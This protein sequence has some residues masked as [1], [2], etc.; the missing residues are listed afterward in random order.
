MTRTEKLSQHLARTEIFREL[1]PRLHRA[2]AEQCE[3]RSYKKEQ[4]IVCQGEAGHEFFL[5]LSGS[6]AVLLEDFA[7]WSEQRI[8]ELGT[9]QSFGES[10]LLTDTRRTATVK[11]EQDT[12]CA[13]LSRESFEKL[14]SKLPEVGLA[15][16]KYLAQR[17]A[18]QCQ[19]TGY[20]FVSGD[21]LVFNPKIYR[22]FP[23]ATLS[24]W[25]A[26]PLALNGRTITVALTRPNDAEAVKALQR[27]VPGFG[28]ELVACTFEDYRAF[29][30][31][32]LLD[33]QAPSAPSESHT[34]EI[35][36][37]DGTKVS[38]P[39]RSVVSAMHSSAESRV[40]AEMES[41]STLLLAHRKGELQ[42]FLPPLAKNETLN[43]RRQLDDLLND[44]SRPAE[45]H[46]VSL[47]LGGRPA[48]LA[49]T[50]LRSPARSRYSIERTD[51]DTAVPP[52]A[53]LFPSAAIANLVKGAL[54]WEG[55]TLLI[56]GPKNSGLSTTLYSLLQSRDEPLRRRN[57]VLFEEHPLVPQNELLQLP[58]SREIEPLLSVAALQKPEIIA[59]DSLQAYQMQELVHLPDVESVVV[60]TYRGNDLL[61]ILAQCAEE[62]D[63]RSA[64]LH[65]IGLILRQKLVRRVCSNC[66]REFEPDPEQLQELRQSGL[67]NPEGRY[68][69]GDGC[70]DCAHT[71]V[72]GQVALFEGLHCS[73]KLLDSLA[74][75]HAKPQTKLDALRESMAFSFKS[76]A[77]LLLS[78][79]LLD[80]LEA[81]RMF[82]A[83]S[84]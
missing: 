17:L 66:C 52:V 63:G 3:L 81:L 19:L 37:A 18:I 7:L 53:S 76:F 45:S 72:R 30:N 62:S 80:P 61:D 65:R 40:I 29:R 9:G 60:A 44:T 54:N 14:M 48:Q 69:R 70:E 28:L 74:G 56:Y 59:F 11:A 77:R 64:S 5:V 13:V 12:T 25:K 1:Q 46:T 41:E 35:V 57:I 43:L 6:V 22:A 84:T 47:K 49:I 38:P 34:I 2:I 20:R 26:I 71:G 51:L 15:I 67:D 39:L 8:L 79:G 10:A 21:E 42:P 23:S 36:L 4:K 55:R 83:S 75:L 73:R 68:L 58:L 32:H 31:R 16:S 78:Q 50:A 27:E 82:P 24:K 33:P